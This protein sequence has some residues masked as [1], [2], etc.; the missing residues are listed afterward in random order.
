M[1][2]NQ[3]L[4]SHFLNLYTVAL[5]DSMI[6]TKELEFLYQFG[7]ERGVSSEKIDEIIS[8]PHKI[9]FT[10]PENVFQKIDHLF[11]FAHMVLAD[12]KIDTR[13]IDIFKK[14]CIKYSFEEENI[15]DLIEFLIEEAKKGTPK[16]EIFEI[17]QN[18]LGKE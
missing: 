4:E 13:E 12:G 3:E 10:I 8:N 2:L 14:I 18:N 15:P 6:D 1:K 9:R 7:E 11:D 5:S 17:V 16:D